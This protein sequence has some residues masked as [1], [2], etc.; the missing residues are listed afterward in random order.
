[1]HYY[2]FNIGDYRRKTAH[3]SLVE[4]GIYRALLDTYYLEQSPLTLDIANL[5]RMHCVR[6][7][8]EKEALRNV[9][10]DFF[11]KSDD[12]YRNPACDKQIEKYEEKSDKARKSAQTRWNNANALRTHTE[13]NADG[14]H[15]E[16]VSDANHKPITNNQEPDLK[17]G[18]KPSASP[19]P[20]QQVVDVYHQ[21]IPTMPKVQV[22]TDARK[23]AIKN[24]WNKRKK[25]NGSFN[26]ENWEAYCRFISSHCGWMTESRP[27]GDGTF[28][29]PKNLDYILTDKCYV[30]VKEDRAN[31]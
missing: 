2:R 29:K 16:C 13:G 4:H 19:V 7:V 1:M 12:G 30:A 6:T 14:M 26:I 28:W 18:E 15:D 5:E 9:L 22:L 20:Y 3:L 10:T 31:D 27:R 21:S 11:I 8:D 17:T 25:E 24:F 23:R